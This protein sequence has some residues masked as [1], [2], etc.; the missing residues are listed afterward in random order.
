MQSLGAQMEKFMKEKEAHVTASEDSVQQLG[1]QPIETIREQ[2]QMIEDL[3]KVVVYLRKEKEVLEAKYELSMLECKRL[4]GKVAGVQK[5][6]DETRAELT[7]QLEKC[8]STAVDEAQFT[9][10]KSELQQL[11]VLRERFV[12]WHFVT[13]LY[14]CLFS[15]MFY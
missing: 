10:L 8:D 12:R 15:V 6:L 4:E 14:V 13:C 1:E 5:T 3:R 7:K 11:E 2:R 9:R